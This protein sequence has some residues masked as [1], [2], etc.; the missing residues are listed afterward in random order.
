MNPNQPSRNNVLVA[1]LIV[2]FVSALPKI[3]LQEVFGQTI[4]AALQ[5]QFSLG[6]IGLGLLTTLAWRSLRSLRPFL[7]LLAVWIA[8]QWLVFERLAKQPL[9]RGWLRDPSFSVSMLTELALKLLITLVVIL[10]LVLLGKERQDFYLA[11]GDPS[12]PARPIRWLGVNPGDRWN[13]V[14]R[15]GTIFISLG[16]LAFLVIAGRPS[17]STL[18]QALPYLP[19]V[20][21]AAALNAFYE[22]VTY[23]GA[24]LGVMEGPVGPRQA[25]YMTAAYFGIGHF[26]GV[27]YGVIGVLLAGFLGWFLARS[28]QDT[29]GMFW[30]WFIHFWQDVWIFAFMAIGSIIPGGG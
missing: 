16:T 13:A 30:A 2:L 20:L 23:K 28:M 17:L 6:V 8:F 7:A 5:T 14:G 24:F 21:L 18:A 11:K 12:A 19:A 1:W 29:R 22:E 26:Y 3:V 15:W 25:L 9:L 10:T 27:P 4:S